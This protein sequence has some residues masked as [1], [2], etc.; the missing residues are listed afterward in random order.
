MAVS[1]KQI[2]ERV[3][4]SIALVSRVLSGKAREVGI[5]EATIAKVM[6]A[7]EEMGY[8]PSA[9]ALTLKGKSSNTIGVVVYDFKDPFFGAMIEELQSQAHG[10][11][12]S[13]VLAGFQQRIPEA[14]DLAPLLKHAIDGLII[15]GSEDDSEWMKAFRDIPVVRIG[16]GRAEEQTVRMSIDE[17]D[18]ADQLLRYLSGQGLHKLAFIH[19]HFAAHRVRF[20]ALEKRAEA[21]G[22]SVRRVLSD[23]WAFEAGRKETEAILAANGIEAIVCATDKIA[24]GALHAMHDADR[25]LPVTGFDDIPAAA[26]FLPPITTIRQPYV[27]IAAK[28]FEAAVE[29]ASTGMMLFKGELKVR[30]S[31]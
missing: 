15:L 25:R 4:V 26:Q 9:A 28:A 30:K 23:G 27:E 17:D 12:Y 8:V 1:Q 21:Y 6:K 2:A 31:A 5:A 13:L 22:C 18:A 7:A 29:P 11:G 16:H 14:A 24:M 10:R 3:G 20:Q 19:E